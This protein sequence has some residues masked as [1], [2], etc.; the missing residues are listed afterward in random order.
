MRWWV[1]IGIAASCAVALWFAGSIAAPTSVVAPA[2]A[3]PP[4]DRVDAVLEATGSSALELADATREARVEVRAP[5][6]DPNP[7]LTSDGAGHGVLRGRLLDSRGAPIRGARVW[8]PSIGWWQW[9]HS[10]TGADGRFELMLRMRNAQADPTVATLRQVRL[11]A[12][13]RGPAQ[14]RVFD[15]SESWWPGELDVGDWQLEAD[16]VVA[17]VR[18]RDELDALIDP[19]DVVLERRSHGL[20]QTEQISSSDLLRVGAAEVELRDLKLPARVQL[21]ARRESAAGGAW[22]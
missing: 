1:G 4:P 8:T 15:L 16:F 19:L 11:H 22:V 6:E 7:I 2:F 13:P 9:T 12:Q 17:R 20:G 10:N 3:A 14:Q 21:R 5:F 18:V